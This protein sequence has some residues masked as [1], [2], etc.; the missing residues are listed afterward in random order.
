EKGFSS[1]TPIK[2]CLSDDYSYDEIRCVVEDEARK[3]KSESSTPG[4]HNFDPELFESL[5]NF[6]LQLAKEEHL[7]AYVFFHDSVL[8]SLATIKPQSIEDLS[9]IKGLGQIKISKYGKQIL[10][11]IHNRPVATSLENGMNF[12]ADLKK[13][14][15][16]KFLSQIHPKELKG[17]WTS[18]YALDFNSRFSGSLWQRTEIGELVYRFKYN[19]ELHLAKVLVNKLIE[20]MDSHPEFKSVDGVLAIPPSKHR[21]TDP[22]SLIAEGV[23]DKI[24]APYLKDTLLKRRPTR[25]QKEMTN[26]VQKKSNVDGAFAVQKSVQSK[27]LLLLDDLYDSGATLNEAVLTL[28]R[29]GANALFVLTLTRT[30]HADN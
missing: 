30:I 7:P 9:E 26:L 28:R 3:L 14:A 17:A 20:F 22:M 8:R 18:G 27:N 5:K 12:N 10:N 1:L 24:K 15:I 6:R 23:A 13:D 2:E 11:V 16:G 25:L 21:V 29:A 4:N 19:A